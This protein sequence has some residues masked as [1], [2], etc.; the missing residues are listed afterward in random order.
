M[1]RL[2]RC[3]I[4]GKARNAHAGAIGVGDTPVRL[5]AVEQVL[6]GSAIDEARA[7]FGPIMR[8]RNEL[9]RFV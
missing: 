5:T 7:I 9:G 4:C 3:W 2:R 6:N 8:Q 1:R